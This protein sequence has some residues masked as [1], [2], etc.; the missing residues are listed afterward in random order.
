[1]I[2]VIIDRQGRRCKSTRMQLSIGNI[3]CRQEN[4]R[5]NKVWNEMNIEARPLCITQNAFRKQL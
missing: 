2:L 3:T 5:I 1:M 4:D